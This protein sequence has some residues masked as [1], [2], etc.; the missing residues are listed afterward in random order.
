MWNVFCTTSTRNIKIIHIELLLAAEVVDLHFQG[1]QKLVSDW[2]I[3]P[4]RLIVLGKLN[5]LR[6][7]TEWVDR[8]GKKTDYFCV[9]EIVYG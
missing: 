3:I 7:E 6:H 5:H 4:E 9:V 2:L 1:P 8:E